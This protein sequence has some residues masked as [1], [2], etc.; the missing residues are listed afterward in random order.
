M[1]NLL[2]SIEEIVAEVVVAEVECIVVEE[3]VV[4]IVLKAAATV[5][6]NCSTLELAMELQNWFKI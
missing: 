5:V 2:T 4:L 6:D 1:L 3:F